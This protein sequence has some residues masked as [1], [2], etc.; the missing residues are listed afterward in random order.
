MERVINGWASSREGAEFVN[1]SSQ[2]FRSALRLEAK[3]SLAMDG[4]VPF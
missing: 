2:I 4:A 3:D 1:Q